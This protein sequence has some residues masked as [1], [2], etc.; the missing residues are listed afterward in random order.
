MRFILTTVGISTLLNGIRLLELEQQE[1]EH[2]RKQFIKHSNHAQ[3]PADV[4]AYV[5]R[6]VAAVTA[7]LEIDGVV[8]NRRLSAELNGIYG[9]YQAG[10]SQAGQDFHY[11][12]GTDTALG[13]KAATVIKHFLERFDF[14]VQI[15]IPAGLSTS[16][17]ETFGRG[18]KTLLSQCEALIP[19]Y[20]DSNYEIIF[21]LTGAFKSL[22]GYLNIIGMFHADHLAYIFEGSS[23]LIRIPR[24]PIMVDTDQ[25]QPYIVALARMNDDAPH[26]YTRTEVAGL[27][28]AL[29]DIQTIDDIQFVCLSTWGQLIW[30][31]VEKEL[32]AQPTLLQLENIA[33]SEQFQKLYKN[34]RPAE[35]VEVNK[36]LVTITNLLAANAGDIT[37]LKTHGGLLYDNY[38]GTQTSQGLPIG[39]FRLNQARRVSCTYQDGTLELRK[40]GAHDFVNKAP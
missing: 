33:Y 30:A 13:K 17:S 35:R 15:E 31:R 20:R 38:T 28:A 14:T 29:L 36:A 10:F 11:L 7:L 4:E 6:V 39:H 26:L 1:A 32:L 21:N 40:F 5:S 8:A 34:A 27:P 23:E 25:L 24:L 16:N 3:L 37:S 12:V 22:Q 18:I 9:L 2:V 19:G